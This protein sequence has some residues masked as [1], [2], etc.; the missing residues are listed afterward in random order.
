[1]QVS[2]PSGNGVEHDNGHA[3]LQVTDAFRGKGES[4]PRPILAC[5]ADQ[6]D[7]GAELRSSLI[8]EDMHRNPVNAGEIHR[9]R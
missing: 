7:G 9:R 1:M 5:R 3:S 6:L 4:A 2:A 8:L